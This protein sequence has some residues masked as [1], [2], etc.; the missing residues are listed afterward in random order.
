[1]AK[2]KW[3]T[4]EPGQVEL[5]PDGGFPFPGPFATIVTPWSSNL[6]IGD[7]LMVAFPNHPGYAGLVGQMYGRL[8]NKSPFP[9]LH[10]VVFITDDIIVTGSIGMYLGTYRT[11]EFGPKNI[12]LRMTRHLILFGGKK[13][14]IPDFNFLMPIVSE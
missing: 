3:K 5:E 6:N 8:K 1:M 14:F 10:P 9:F 13:Y 7:L 12:P 11:N 4:P 2:V